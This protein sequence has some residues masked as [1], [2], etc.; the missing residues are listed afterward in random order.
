MAAS[1]GGEARSIDPAAWRG[2]RVLVVAPHQD[3]E[4]FGAGGTAYLAAR[5]GAEVH[6]VVAAR[7]D[8][9]ITGGVT[10]AVREAESIRCCEL[11]GTRPPVFLR[12]PSPQLRED[13]LGAGR[14]AAEALGVR[15]DVLLVPSPLERHA[16]HRAT[17]LA[18]LCGELGTPEAEWWGWCVWSE[19]PPGPG[20]GEVDVTEA[21]SP[22]TLAMSAHVSQNADRKLAAGQSARDYATA[23]FARLTGAEPRK[24][25][26][27]LLDCS[28]LGRLQPAPATAAQARERAASFA[29]EWLARWA[30]SVWD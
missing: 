5:A 18:A 3:D 12:L 27:R 25:V 30:A 23:T 11:L 19:I 13:P 26:E 1:G 16:T 29:R 6:V 9:G 21:R 2:R 4:A 22:K 8:G 20:T 15:F 17:L 24:A 28:A 10:P 7:G 14:A